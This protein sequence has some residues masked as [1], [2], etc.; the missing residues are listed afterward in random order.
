MLYLWTPLGAPAVPQTQPSLPK[1][2]A[3]QFTCRG[4]RRCV[5]RR[6]WSFRRHLTRSRVHARQWRHRSAVRVEWTVGDET[7]R[8]RCQFLYR[9][10]THALSPARIQSPQLFSRS[11]SNV[12]FIRRLDSQYRTRKTCCIM[13]IARC[14]WKF[15]PIV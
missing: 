11:V 12:C 13:E 15:R 2:K 6:E 9:A 5:H 1:V 14:R 8:Y 3:V 4:S 7:R 10:A